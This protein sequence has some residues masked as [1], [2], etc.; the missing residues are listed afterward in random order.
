MENT[1][2]TGTQHTIHAISMC[3]CLSLSL[4][5]ISI[6]ELANQTLSEN[7]LNEDPPQSLSEYIASLNVS[8]AEYV[9]RVEEYQEIANSTATSNELGDS[10]LNAVSCV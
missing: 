8:V 6:A 5:D 2:S 3:P 9:E 10:I 7:T 4:Q 1:S